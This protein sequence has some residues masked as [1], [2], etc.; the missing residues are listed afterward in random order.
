MEQVLTKALAFVAVIA[1]GYFLKK[2]G[3]FKPHDYELIA[4][5]VLNITLPCAVI[6]SFAAFKM[7]YTLFILTL[8]G[9][10]GN[11]LMIAWG[12]ILTRYQTNAAKIFYVFN[13]AGYNIGCFTLPFAQSFLGPFA[14]VATCMF[15][16]GNSIMCTGGTYALTSGLVHTGEKYEPVNL[17]SIAAKLLGSVPFVVYMLMLVCAVLQLHL[18]QPV[19]T[20]TGLIGGANTFFS[21]LMIGIGGHK[22]VRYSS[23]LLA[24]SCEASRSPVPS[25][26]RTQMEQ[27]TRTYWLMGVAFCCGSATITHSDSELFLLR[28]VPNTTSGKRSRSRFSR[29]R[30]KRGVLVGGWNT[31]MR[32]PCRSSA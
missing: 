27:R 15:D 4:K 2:R 16:V 1:L 23:M 26:L 9:F 10:C 20:L 24:S 14:V 28:S 6:T 13:L 25:S 12:F 5:I 32:P 21:M 18:P 30:S 8:I 19:Y 29:I 11:L 7:D 17:R 31:L 22:P 3:F